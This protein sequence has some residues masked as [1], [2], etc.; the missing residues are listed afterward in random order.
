MRI[1]GFLLLS[2]LSFNIYAQ[3]TTETSGAVL[4]KNNCSACHSIGEGRLVGPDLKGVN[5][6]RSEEWL[7]KWIKSSQSLVKSGDKDAVALFNEFNKVVMI[8]YAF[9]TDDQIKSILAYVKETEAAPAAAAV[10]ADQKEVVVS[11]NE[12]VSFS[13]TEIFLFGILVLLLLV[14]LMLARLV[15]RL[16]DRLSD[17]YSNDRAFFKK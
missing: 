13:N 12:S 1:I 11:K 4:Y 14:I 3:S 9:L 15:I 6:R 10:Q 16:S 2:V 7:M 17:F 8:D 5:D